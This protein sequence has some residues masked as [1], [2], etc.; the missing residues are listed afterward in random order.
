[1]GC[2]SS[3]YDRLDAE[4]DGLD[5]PNVLYK[6][7]IV[8]E[9]VTTHRLNFHDPVY[10]DKCCDICNR[11]D[12]VISWNSIDGLVNGGSVKRRLCMNCIY[13]AVRII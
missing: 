4:P 8:S 3:K 2:R 11:N 10:T 9:Y 5:D 12:T 1:M 6:K 13:D 7:K